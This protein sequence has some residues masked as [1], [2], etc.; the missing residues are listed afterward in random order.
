VS[1]NLNL[2]VGVAAGGADGTGLAWFAPIGTTAPTDATT[3][4]NAGFLNA[5]GISEDGLTVSFEEDTTD[6]RFYGSRAIQRRVTTNESQTFGITFMEHNETAL[7]IYHKKALNSISPA[8]STG[9][10][11]LTTGAAAAEN[12]A[13][14]FQIVDDDRLTRIYAPNVEVTGRGDLQYSAGNP[15]QFEVTFTAY[16]N[17]SGVA[18]QWFFALPNLG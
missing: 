5:G 1:D 2:V 7:A 13:A 15:V 10:F 18:I 3:A 9:A 12:Y 6:I 4:L 16:P 8:V 14:V 17:S 11:S